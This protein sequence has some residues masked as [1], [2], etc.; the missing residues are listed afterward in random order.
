[1]RVFLDTSYFIAILYPRDQ[2]H[3]KAVRALHS[4]DEAFTSAFVINETI[5]LLQSR[6]SLSA[7]LEF[8]RDLRSGSSV[9]V[10][11]SDAALQEEAWD[12]FAKWGPAGANAIDCTSFAMMRR[13]ACRKALTFDKHFRT[14]GFDILT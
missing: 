10:M 3:P 2:W 12:L 7:A 8:L 1:M 4:E 9:R 6:G 5:S 14:A 13:L 11:H